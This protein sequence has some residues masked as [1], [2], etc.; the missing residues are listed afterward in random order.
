LSA[1]LTDPLSETALTIA[2]VYGSYAVAASLGRSGLIAVAIVGLYYGRVSGRGERLE[3]ARSSVV[4]FWSLAAFVANSVAFL[5]IGLS[6]DIYRLYGSLPEILVAYLAVTLAR[7]AAVYP[8]LA[9]FDNFGLKTPFKWKNVAM[10]G[11]MR[12]AISTALIASLPSN[13]PDGELIASMVLG[14]AFISIMLQGPLL[15]RYIKGRFKEEMKQE[16]GRIEAMLTATILDIKEIQDLKS[17][18]AEN[19]EELIQ[20]LEADK[21]KLEEVVTSLKEE[22]SQEKEIKE[23]NDDKG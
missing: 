16:R 20:R 21:E 4:A 13:L 10:L 9:I 12:G 15:S 18:Q 17:S 22:M 2:S 1:H 14:V 19:Q 23:Q 6:T 7:A 3:S 11:G 8:I 5:F